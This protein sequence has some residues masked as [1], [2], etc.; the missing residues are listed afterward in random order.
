ML[1]VLQKFFI[2][3]FPCLSLDKYDAAKLFMLQPLAS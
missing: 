3:F 2:Y 1:H